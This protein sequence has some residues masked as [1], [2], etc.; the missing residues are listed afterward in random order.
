[1]KATASYRERFWPGLRYFRECFSWKALAVDL[2]SELALPVIQQLPEQY[3]RFYFANA[4]RPCCA[5]H[6]VRHYALLTLGFFR[7][8]ICTSHA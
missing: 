8:S 4:R 3:V 2:P 7:I 5:K 1:M 6:S